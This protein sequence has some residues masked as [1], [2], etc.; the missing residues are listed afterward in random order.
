MTV[1]D[2]F[3]RNLKKMVRERIFA[4]FIGGILAL[5][6]S[7]ALLGV[8]YFLMVALLFKLEM[9]NK[10][11]IYSVPLVII[12]L[13]L[14]VYP[15]VAD[16]DSTIIEYDVPEQSERFGLMGDVNPMNSVRNAG[17]MMFVTFAFR[18]FFIGVKLIGN[19]MNLIFAP[20]RDIYRLIEALGDG[21]SV[22]L[23]TLSEQLFMDPV[24]VIVHLKRLDAVIFM[25]N[26]VKLSS[27]WYNKL[28]G[29]D[30]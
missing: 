14:I 29:I 6:G 13:I 10:E 19:A 11:I 17:Y 16:T 3:Y 24:S 9:P 22:E 23:K 25:D 20:F 26:R 8:M 1:E 12:V 21:Q 4:L 18:L 30:E 28:Y 2:I 15:F 7:L 5:T 27:K